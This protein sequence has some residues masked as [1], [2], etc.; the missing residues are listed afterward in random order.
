MIGRKEE[1]KGKG[2]KEE[3]VG[4]W[5]REGEKDWGND[6]PASSQQKVIHPSSTVM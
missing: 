6:C 3:G 2:R 5:A 4:G 1:E